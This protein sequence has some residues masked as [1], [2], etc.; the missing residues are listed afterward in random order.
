MHPNASDSHGWARLEGRV[1]SHV[2][3]SVEPSAAAFLP[4]A[5]QQEAGPEAKVPGSTPGTQ[6]WKAGIPG[7]TSA[8]AQ[9]YTYQLSPSRKASPGAGADGKPLH[10]P[11]G[12]RE[13][14]GRDGAG[15]LQVGRARRQVLSTV[16]LSRGEGGVRPASGANNLAARR[17][18]WVTQVLKG[19]LWMRRKASV[20]AT[21]LLS[22]RQGMCHL[23]RDRPL[24]PTPSL[25]VGTRVHA[26]GDPQG[27]QVKHSLA[28]RS[29][30]PFRKWNFFRKPAPTKESQR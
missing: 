13:E 12:Q 15:Q 17:D 19:R 16:I 10:H 22:N 1:V 25:P 4:G 23:Y 14:Q 11:Q 24:G 3:G 2:G 21:Y 30:L 18:R 27:T 9:T 29:T 8:T 7:N 5:H 26:T 6:R 20:E 28:H